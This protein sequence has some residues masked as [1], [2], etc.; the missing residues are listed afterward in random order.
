MKQIKP[1]ENFRINEAEAT[2]L[3]NGSTHKDP[4]TGK[5]QK[6]KWMETIGQDLKF[7]VN[8]NIKFYYDDVT[9]SFELIDLDNG[10]RY[11]G[12]LKIK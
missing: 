2:R 7:D 4:V 12:M 1:F 11:D 5:P 3:P 8:K 6:V 10:I 9:K